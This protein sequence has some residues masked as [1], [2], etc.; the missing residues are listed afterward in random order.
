MSQGSGTHLHLEKKSKNQKPI[1][2]PKTNKKQP[3][4]TNSKTP[5]CWGRLAGPTHSVT[6]KT[7][8][9]REMPQHGA[10]THRD[11][12]QCVIVGRMGAA[13]LRPRIR[14]D[15]GWLY[16]PVPCIFFFFPFSVR[17]SHQHQQHSSS[18]SS[19]RGLLC[20]LS[21]VYPVQQSVAFAM[22]QV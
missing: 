22:Y 14:K 16:V 4:D 20:F 11:A 9:R 6:S 18:T 17:I 3:T 5:S 10:S 15:Q 2:E 13:S 8:K 1:R 7:F 19:S 21:S 12:K